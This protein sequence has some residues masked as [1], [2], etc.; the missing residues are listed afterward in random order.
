M[1][2]F[3][4]LFFTFFLRFVFIDFTE[5]LER[6]DSEIR[7]HVAIMCVCVYLYIDRY[8]YRYLYVDRYI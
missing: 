7:L 5:I 2:S 3:Y 8:I 4:V 1:L 6:R